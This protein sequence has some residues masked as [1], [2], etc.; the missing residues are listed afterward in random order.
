MQKMGNKI[1]LKFDDD[2][3]V[4]SVAILGFIIGN[5]DGDFDQAVARMVDSRTL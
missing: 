5:A 3:T 4:T 1:V 2:L